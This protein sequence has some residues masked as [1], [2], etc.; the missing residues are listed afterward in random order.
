MLARNNLAN[1]LSQRGE[2]A[3][4]QELLD[5]ASKASLA[6]RVSSPR[7]WTIRLNLAAMARARNDDQG[8]L[9][10]VDEASRDYPGIWGVAR[11]KAELVR[12]MCGPE[13]ALPIMEEFTR[14]RWWHCEAFIAM[15]RLLWESGDTALAEKAF[16][17]AS[18]LDVHDAESLSCLAILRMQQNRLEDAFQTQ[19][20]AV[21]RQPD[22]IR[23]YLLLSDILQKMGRT[24]EARAA[25]AQVDRLKAFAQSQPVAN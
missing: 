3:E 15:G 13:S 25:T 11:Y 20:R 24:A 6:Q 7:A 23:P 12:A 10:I 4:A 17:H 9:A 22:E 19:S 1:L 2:K 21:S 16:R 8:A 14:N 5:S 18:W